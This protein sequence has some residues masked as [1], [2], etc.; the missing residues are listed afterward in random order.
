VAF[1]V[2]YQARPVERDELGDAFALSGERDIGM[3]DGG[4]GGGGHAVL[5]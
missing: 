4:G 3:G 1:F 5:M 2:V